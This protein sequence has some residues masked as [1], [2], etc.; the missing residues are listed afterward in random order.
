MIKR[1]FFLTVF[2]SFA[3]VSAYAGLAITP[4]RQEV[5]LTPGKT[6]EGTYNV[7]NEYATPVKIKADF[8]D[9][10]VLPENKNS[11]ISDWLSIS[12]TEFP[13]QPGESKDVSY[14]I[15]LPVTAQGVSVAMLSFIPEFESEQGVTMMVSVS[16]YV[17]AAGTEKADWEIQDVKITKTA[18]EFTVSALVNDKG[19]VHIRPAGTVSVLSGNKTLFT[20]DFAEGR[21]VYPG[22]SRTIVASNNNSVS[23]EEGKYTAVADISGAGQEKKKT[24]DF[25]INNSGEVIVK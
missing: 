18:S 15:H 11:K 10:F 22:T 9:W 25:V 7:R 17:T 24:T 8:R 12:P 20:L 16:L 2:I 5:S 23:L 6:F 1:I 19:N 13:L 21:P 4:A 14:T 3:A